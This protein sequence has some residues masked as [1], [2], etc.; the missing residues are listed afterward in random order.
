MLFP[1]SSSTLSQN[2]TLHGGG[3]LYEQ[4]S[5]EKVIFFHHALNWSVICH[6]DRCEAT[7]DV[8]EH[9]TSVAFARLF[10][11]PLCTELM[12]VSSLSLSLCSDYCSIVS[13]EAHLKTISLVALHYE[14]YLQM[15]VQ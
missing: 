6:S 12:L 11:F 8:P 4:R 5:T 7:R 10:L 9:I 13:L 14:L 3:M 1:S 15:T 2:F